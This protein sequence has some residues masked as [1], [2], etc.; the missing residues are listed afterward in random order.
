MPVAFGVPTPAGP[1]N[2]P[3]QQQRPRAQNRGLGSNYESAP[4]P[5]DRVHT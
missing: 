4:Y 5:T 3:R 1:S 2:I